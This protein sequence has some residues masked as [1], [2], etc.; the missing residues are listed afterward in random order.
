MRSK[1][2]T[3]THSERP[4]VYDKAVSLIPSSHTETCC[5]IK[6]DATHRTWTH[7]PRRRRKLKK[8]EHPLDPIPS[9]SLS[10]GPSNKG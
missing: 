2:K 6:S 9:P 7:F 8:E 4:V 3:V 5:Q 1:V 10:L